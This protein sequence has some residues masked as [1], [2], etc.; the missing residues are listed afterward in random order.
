MNSKKII[1]NILFINIAST[2]AIFLST[3]KAAEE[4]AFVNGALI[5]T[6]SIKSIENLSKTGKATGLLKDI[7]NFSNQNPQELANLLNQQFE[8]PLVLTSRLMNSSIGNVIIKRITKVIHPIKV[9]DT[10][11]SVPAIRAG[12]IKGLVKGEGKINLIG[13]LK[14]YPNKVMAVNIPALT[15]VTNKVDTINDLVKFFSDSPLEGLKKGNVK[16]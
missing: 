10:S 6:I 2:A 4:I 12:V 13:F 16:P 9:P 15:K 3:A 5:R 11:V 1:T 8:M 7:I 14:A